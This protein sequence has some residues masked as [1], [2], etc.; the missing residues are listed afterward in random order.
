MKHKKVFVG[1]SLVLGLMQ[2]GAYAQFD[3]VLELSNLDGSNGFA[4][5]GVSAFDAAGRSIDTAG[6]INGDGIND[7]I[8]GAP[9]AANSNGRTGNSYVVFGSGNSS[10]S[11]I[12]LSG[13]N[14]KNGFTIHGLTTSTSF[15]SFGNFGVSVSHAGD[16]NSDGL[17]DLIIGAPYADSNGNTNPGSSYVIF[18][19]EL[20]IPHPFDPSNLDGFN[21]FSINGVADDDQSGRSVSAA[22]DFNGDGIDDL[23]IG[24]PF[25]D[26]DTNSDAGSSYVVFGAAGG[27][28]HPLN[29]STLNGSNGFRLDGVAVNDNFG[30]AFSAAGDING[31]GIDDLIVGTG[32]ADPGDVNNAGSSY[33]LFGF[34]GS[35]PSTMDIN[36]I[37]GTN[38]FV[39]NGFASGDFLGGSVGAAGDINGDGLGDL[40]IGAT[41]A[42]VNG[43]VNVGKSHVL[44]GSVNPI[45][46]PF[47]LSSL[48]GN[49]GFTIHGIGLS[50]FSGGSV[51][52]AGDVNHDGVD[53]LVIGGVSADP[54]GLF[55]AGSGY[56]V[57]GSDLIFMDGF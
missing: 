32:F 20:A 56:V 52:S 35:R 49:N 3:P 33:V 9:F 29:L 22:G 47:N 16:I 45:P 10:L 1:V 19:S 30:G 43:L 41:G 57:F 11:T 5:N 48:D 13:L 53:D 6:D 18:G 55:D 54:N 14:G 44:F 7:V 51:N 24:A 40:I 23:I 42:D 8:I 17:D 31:D 37:N 2:Q 39:I 46:H 36:D 26:P 28:T 4:V 25:A 21:G 27:L 12:D 38:G 34:S 50:G 15:G